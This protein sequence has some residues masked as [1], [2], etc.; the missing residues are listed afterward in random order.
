MGA[1]RLARSKLWISYFED[2]GTVPPPFNI[3]PT[4]KT[5][6][7]IFKWVYIQFCGGSNKMKKE[8][9]K[10]VRVRNLALLVIII[11]FSQKL[12]ISDCN[13]SMN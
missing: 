5:V 4:P 7:Y 8:H 12:N 10:T 13:I 11:T 1:N 2:G 9:L 6:F 3:I